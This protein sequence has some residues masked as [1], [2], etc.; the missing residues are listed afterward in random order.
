[1]KTIT[2]LPKVIDK[3]GLGGGHCDWY[4][5]WIYNYY[6]IQLYV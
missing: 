5:S 6:S 1:V 2:D 3:W 4:G